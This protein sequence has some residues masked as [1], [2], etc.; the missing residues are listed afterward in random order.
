MTS[1]IIEKTKE[2]LAEYEKRH[3]EILNSAM[4]LFNENGYPGTTTA[5]IAKE[6]G[7]TERTMFRHFKNKQVLFFECIFSIVGE[8]S[9]LWQQEMKEGAG[10]GMDYLRA[11]AR[12][13]GKFVLQNP[14]K[15]MFFVHLFSYRGMPE[16]DEVFKNYIEDSLNEAEKAFIA[17]KE[18][19]EMKS[20]LHPRILAGVFLAQYFTTVFLQEFM[21]PEI[22]N[23]ETALKLA[24]SVMMIE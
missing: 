22:F 10:V 7:V 1:N 17:I 15:C 13:Y 20:D 16:V 4:K 11:V 12:S 14:D 21:P 2:K 18:K 5:S 8:L 24:N 23:E 6:A 3:Q 9:D 19:G